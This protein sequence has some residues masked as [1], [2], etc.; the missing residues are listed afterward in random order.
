MK[1]EMNAGIEVL[2]HEIKK[3]EL[4]IEMFEKENEGENDADK[5]DTNCLMIRGLKDL[6]KSYKT[7][8]TRLHTGK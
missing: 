8:I 6:I 2:E 1:K 5:I 4:G 3:L 7:C